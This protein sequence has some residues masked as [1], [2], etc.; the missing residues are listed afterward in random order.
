MSSLSQWFGFNRTVSAEEL[1]EIFPVP[2]ARQDFVS[3]DVVAIYSKVLTDVLERTHGLSEEQTA[4]MW[5]SC[6]KSSATDGMITLIAKAMSEKKDLFLVYEKAVKVIRPAT[7]D[8][9]SKIKADYIA[10]GES[11]IGIFI[12]FKNFKRADMVKFYIELEYLTVGSLYKSMNLSKAVQL[13]FADLRSSVSLAD[14]A[15]VKTQAI[16]IA[17]SLSA[18]KDVM[19]DAKDEI[20]TSTPD[21]KSVDASIDFITKKLSFYLGLPAAWITGEQTGG[22]GT[23]G[24]N[25]MRA[26][27]R[28]L[29]AYFVS[30]V[31]PTLEAIFGIAV[32]YKSQ[33]FRQ[34][35]GSV[36]ILKVFGL[37]DDT[38]ISAENKRKIINQMLDLPEDAKGDAPKKPHAQLP[39]PAAKQ[40]ASTR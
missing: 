25:D 38:L 6:V 33:D 28:G 21:L 40:E 17:K 29:K 8:E 3:T 4:L 31:K 11:K 27:E 37:I 2:V 9:T 14:T 7:D 22:L 39:A 24:E 30:I 1:P 34:V 5:D 12:S 23:T 18:G 13:K 10:E 36:E 35:E 26:V 20:T 19:L 15:D 16:A 32:S